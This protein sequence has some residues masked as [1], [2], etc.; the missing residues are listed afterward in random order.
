MFE[1]FTTKK[2]LIISIWLNV[3][4]AGAIIALIVNR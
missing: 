1:R 3:M 2:W 4:E